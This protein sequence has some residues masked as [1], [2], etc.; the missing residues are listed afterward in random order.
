[1]LI[2]TSHARHLL[3]EYHL[4]MKEETIPFNMSFGRILA[5]DIFADRDFPPF[6]RV[7]MDGIAVK[8]SE[9]NRAWRLVGVQRAGQKPFRFKDKEV[10]DEAIEIMTGAACP[11]PFDTIIP[12]EHLFIKGDVAYLKE[13]FTVRFGQNLHLKG[14]DRHRGDKL[15]ENGQ[16][17]GHGE[18]AILASVGKM[19][20][21]VRRNPEILIVSTGDELVDVCQ[22]PKK[23]QIRRSNVYFVQNLLRSEGFISQISHLPDD[24]KILRKKLNKWKTKYD[25]ILMSGGVSMGKSDYIPDTAAFLGFEKIFHGVAQRPGKP[26][27]CGIYDSCLLFGLPGN[28]LSTAVCTAYYVLPYLLSLTQSDNPSRLRTAVLAEDLRFDKP[29][30]RFF[31]AVLHAGYDSKVYAVPIKD[32]GSGDLASLIRAN[33]FVIFPADENHLP[34]GSIVEIVPI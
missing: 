30:T 26:F 4:K 17:I 27:W 19:Y 15:L 25:I 3:S 8:Y 32:H 11:K 2:S 33:S 21:C 34:K 7:A 12:Y 13:E 16:K 23:W 28:P 10:T 1:M 24:P 29:L 22:R 18:I 31:P 5:E 9:A 14:A 20:V 6:D